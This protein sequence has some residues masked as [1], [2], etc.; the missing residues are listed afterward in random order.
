MNEY[1]LTLT[2]C[3]KVC[4]GQK[5]DSIP[6]YHSLHLELQLFSTNYTF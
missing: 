1:E 5:W 4:N 3:G 6:T 2:E